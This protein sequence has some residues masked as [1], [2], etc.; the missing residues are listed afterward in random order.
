MIRHD[1]QRGNGNYSPEFIVMSDF[2]KRDFKRMSS[3]FRIWNNFDL[4]VIRFIVCFYKHLDQKAWPEILA[5]AILTRNLDHHL[6]QKLWPPS[7][8]E[9]WCIQKYMCLLRTVL[10]CLGE[11]GSAGFKFLK[12]KFPKVQVPKV[13]IFNI[14]ISKG[15]VQSSNLQCSNVQ[16]STFQNSNYQKLKLNSIQLSLACYCGILVFWYFGIQFSSVQ[17][18]KGPA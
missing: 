8:P 3:C 18:Q 4:A 10:S 6:D 12:F 1:K 15:Q 7:W 11:W 2:F 14:K 16:T 5:S 13:K 9:L 17:S